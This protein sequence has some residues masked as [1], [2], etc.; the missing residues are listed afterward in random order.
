MELTFNA[1]PTITRFMQSRARRRYL[2][3][4]FGSGKSSACCVEIVRLAAEHPRHSD[5]FRHTRFIIVRNTT[6]QLRDTT[7]KTWFQWFP[8]GSIGEWRAT[9]K[10][11]YI[12]MGDIRSEVSFRALD[13]PDDVSNLLS[14]EVTG[15][16]LNECREIEKEIVEGLDGRLGRWKP[17]PGAWFGMFGD[18]NPPVFDSYWYYIAENLDPNTLEPL[19]EPAWDTFFQPSGL[20]EDAEN[21][22]HLPGGRA[23]Y[24]DM[25]K[26]KDENWINMY[27]HGRYGRGLSGTVVQPLFSRDRHVRDALISIP[28]APIIIAFDFGRT[29]AAVFKQQ[30]A[31]GKVVALDEIVTIESDR[32]GLER[33]LRERV[34][35]R[36]NQRWHGYPICV[37]GDPTGGYATQ[38]SEKT[39][40]DMMCDY[41][42]PRRAI[43]LAYTNDPKTRR[44]ATEHFLAMHGGA[45]YDSRCRYLIRGL[46]GGYHYPKLR[47]K[48][49]TS[50][51]PA[52]NIY[53]HI[54]EA[55]EYANMHY[56][57]GISSPAQMD[58]RKR[59]MA[60]LLQSTN[61]GY[62]TDR[63]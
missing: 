51:N 62:H 11:F 52:K 29:P 49:E 3:G 53:S 58:R 42:I 44:E 4:P 34:I 22:D 43:R 6:P 47:T 17:I 39:C 8:N 14:L 54:C 48:A 46:E 59:M 26:G 35:P 38:V 9:E 63:S 2:Q 24:S 19:A 15:A 56:R 12:K 30:D 33:M 61:P 40:I 20:A 55:D 41:K 45:V 36:L 23:Y 21:L 7:M 27:V 10:T 60:S 37:T 13:N 50:P 57:F 31:T 18:T 5:G 28:T 1:Y 25:V 32:M 16:W